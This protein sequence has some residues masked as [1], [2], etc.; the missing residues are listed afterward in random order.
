MMIRKGLSATWLGQPFV[1]YR[2]S[3]RLVTGVV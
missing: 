3:V 2:L 1:I